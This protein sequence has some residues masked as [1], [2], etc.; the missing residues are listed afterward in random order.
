MMLQLQA[1]QHQPQEKNGTAPH[2]AM[3]IYPT[4]RDVANAKAGEEGFERIFATLLER[5][6]DH[7]NKLHHLQSRITRRVVAV[8]IEWPHN[9]L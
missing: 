1:Q 6:R 9:G 7:R 4:R 3:S 5:G 8:G 2:V